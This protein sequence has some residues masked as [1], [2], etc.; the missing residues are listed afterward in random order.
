MEDYAFLCIYAAGCNALNSADPGIGRLSA[1]G[2]VGRR[3]FGSVR[4]QSAAATS[5]SPT[6][7]VL[8]VL[9]SA[10]CRS[11]AGAGAGQRAWR[12]LVTWPVSPGSLPG[13][14]EMSPVPSYWPVGAA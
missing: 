10:A 4:Q 8:D 13:P 7:R 11:W 12:W 1:L 14:P 2:G 3:S 6:R 9:A 5:R